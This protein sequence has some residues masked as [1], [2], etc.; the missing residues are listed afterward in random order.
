MT[1]TTD[2][3][4]NVTSYEYDLLGRRI[5]VTAP[6]PDGAG[7]LTAP[8]TNFTYDFAGNLLTETD[9]EG[10]VTNVRLRQPLSQHQRHSAGSRRRRFTVGAD[11]DVRLLRGRSAQER[12]RSAQ[13]DDVI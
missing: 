10:N 7:S 4:N 9:P 12:N 1:S 11:H 3:L 6:D 13:P 8:V 2:A 5:K